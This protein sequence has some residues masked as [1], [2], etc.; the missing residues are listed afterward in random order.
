MNFFA[1]TVIVLLRKKF[2]LNTLLKRKKLTEYLLSYC[3]CC[4]KFLVPEMTGNTGGNIRKVIS[5]RGLWGKENKKD[6]PR[7]PWKT[8]FPLVCGLHSFR[9]PAVFFS[10][11]RLVIQP[12]KE[13]VTWQPLYTAVSTSQSWCNH[14]IHPVFSTVSKIDHLLDIRFDAFSSA[15]LLKLYQQR[16]RA[17]MLL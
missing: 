11:Q 13:V 3:Q 9:R 15:K 10:E 7:E 17:C 12:K 16:Y 8:C 4:S 6:H 14:P 2:L 1:T 5:K